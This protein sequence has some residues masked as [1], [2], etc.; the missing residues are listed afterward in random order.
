MRV[1]PVSYS[2]ILNVFFCVNVFEITKTVSLYSFT[3]WLHVLMTACR[4]LRSINLEL[5]HKSTVDPSFYV[6]THSPLSTNCFLI[7]S[8]S[9]VYNS[10]VI[11]MLIII[12]ILQLEINDA[13]IAL[14]LSV[15]LS[16]IKI[17]SDAYCEKL[18][19]ARIKFSTVKILI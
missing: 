6:F 9:Y 4:V 1:T 7:P 5:V 15:Y 13:V 3:L 8:H 16:E 11:E 18:N 12:L 14:S 10:Y 2:R 19:Y 17:Y